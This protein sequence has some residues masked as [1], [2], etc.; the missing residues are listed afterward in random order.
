MRALNLKRLFSW[1]R[2]FNLGPVNLNF[3]LFIILILLA[4]GCINLYN[5]G[6][7]GVSLW[8]EGDYLNAASEVS[9]N[10]NITYL[11]AGLKPL[12]LLF[13]SIAMFI[14]GAFDYVGIAVSAVFGV[15][16]VYS[17]YL[18]A[19]KLFGEKSGL[20]AATILGTTGLFF[21]YSRIIYSDIMLIFFV[22]ITVL[23]YLSTLNS[24]KKIHYFII[25]L[26]ISACFLVKNVGALTLALIFIFELIN[27]AYSKKRDWK[28][29]F[30]KLAVISA[31]AIVIIFFVSYMYKVLA[32]AGKE[33]VVS[34]KSF[35]RV[36]DIIFRLF[37]NPDFTYY[38][39]MYIYIGTPFLFAFL[40]FGA[41]KMFLSKRKNEIIALSWLAF[42]YLFFSLFYQ[43]R[44]KLFVLFLPA[45]SIVIA[46]GIDIKTRDKYARMLFSGAF[47]FLAVSSLYASGSIIG[48]KFQGFRDV[49][50]ELVDMGAEGVVSSNAGVYK[51]YLRNLPLK[52]QTLSIEEPYAQLETLHGEGYT[53]LVMD[54]RAAILNTSFEKDILENYEPVI[55]F[56]DQAIQSHPAIAVY[57]KMGYPEDYDKFIFYSTKIHGTILVYDLDDI[58][59]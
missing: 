16:L 5:I 1:S 59:R 25:G 50:S 14:F 36:Y 37:E 45:M 33:S 2:D 13:I 41:L 35:G 48:Y 39:L 24:R 4:V 51:F 22:T 29:M 55:S 11:G 18:I 31:T 15:L 10:H 58:L 9:E 8:D 38:P 27:I 53:H 3:S 46:R 52:I 54:W 32:P 42:Y 44:M 23:Y 19:R 40:I 43:H 49:S 34:S 21:H 17:T 47:L 28:E 56:E 20:I 57:R 6:E 30:I 7:I 12:Y 26:L